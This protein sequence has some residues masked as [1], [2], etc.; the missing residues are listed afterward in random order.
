DD[1]EIGHAI[2]AAGL[3]VALPPFA[4]AH[5]CVETD[6]TSL[7]NHE[8]RWA[9]TIRSVDPAGFAGTVV[10]HALPLSLMGAALTEF[11]RASVAVIAVAV[12]CRLILKIG[13][14]RALSRPGTGY[15]LFPLRDMLSF[16]VF[17][18]SFFAGRV[19][20]RGSRFRVRA[21]GEL[22]RE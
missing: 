15:W 17:V 20:W 12:L 7:V 1:Y 16:A 2:R 3:E 13:I 9:R 22:A 19:D 8:L 21:D 4:V 18:G 5:R 6:L 10:T 11:S 14:D